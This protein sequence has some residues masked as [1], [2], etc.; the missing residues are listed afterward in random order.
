MP[1]LGF[2]LHVAHPKIVNILVRVE[3]APTLEPQIVQAVLD[4]ILREI[5][6]E[7]ESRL[8]GICHDKVSDAE[9]VFFRDCTVLD[10]KLFLREVKHTIKSVFESW[11]GLVRECFV[12]ELRRMISKQ[13]RKLKL[14]GNKK[15]RAV[16][17][18]YVSELDLDGQVQEVRT[19]LLSV[20]LY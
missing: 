11:R 20:S 3:N 8:S 1:V 19:V 16:E 5:R 17:V 15:R 13:F 18:V 4:K 6:L 14:H 12:P 2:N 9:G 10:E 7:L